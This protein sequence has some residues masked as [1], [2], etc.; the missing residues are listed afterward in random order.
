MDHALGTA[1]VEVQFHQHDPPCA[2]LDALRRRAAEG[3]RVVRGRVRAHPYL[4]TPG[5]GPVWM[6]EGDPTARTRL[7]PSPPVRIHDDML[8]R[9]ARRGW[10][11]RGVDP[12]RAGSNQPVGRPSSR[13]TACSCRHSDPGPLRDQLLELVS[14][15]AT[16]V[17]VGSVL[18]PGDVH[19]RISIH[20]SVDDTV[21]AAARREVTGQ[22]AAQRCADSTRIVPE[23]SVAELPYRDRNR[24]GITS[25]SR[26]D[27]PK[28]L[29]THGW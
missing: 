11:R 17:D 19:G 27:L 24:F 12:A 10:T 15:S 2:G 23:R 1:A 9:R 28:P 14:Y 16:A 13:A 4:A 21:R 5:T 6:A 26:R 29:D 8:A 20:Q 7:S 3:A 25:R 18:E 22:L